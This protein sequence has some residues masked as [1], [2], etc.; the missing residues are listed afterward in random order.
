MV[1]VF[2]QRNDMHMHWTPTLELDGVGECFCHVHVVGFFLNF[3]R[4]Y[5]SL[6]DYI[7]ISLFVMDDSHLSETMV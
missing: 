6:T 7:A 2:S 5:S 4:I 1:G 3:F